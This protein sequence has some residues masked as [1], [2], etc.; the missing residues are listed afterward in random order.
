MNTPTIALMNRT[1]QTVATFEPVTIE[2]PGPIRLRDAL[3]LDEDVTD[4]E[5]MAELRSLPRAAACNSCRH[6]DA[7][8]RGHFAWLWVVDGDDEG[9]DR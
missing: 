5:V 4:D 3:M 9:S 2:T 7:D 6:T 8:S 1:G